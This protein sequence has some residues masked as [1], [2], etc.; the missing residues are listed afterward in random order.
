[1]DSRANN[2]SAF[3]FD[4]VQAIE[5][6]SVDSIGSLYFLLLECLVAEA[7]AE[8]RR[9]HLDLDHLASHVAKCTGLVNVLRGV[10]HNASR[11]RCYV[12]TDLLVKHGA[13][14]Q[15]FLAGD[16]SSEGVAAACYDLSCRAKEHY[17]VADSIISKLK[18]YSVKSL[19]LPI[20]FAHIFL[21]RMEEVNF[22][23]FD[24][25][26]QRRETNLPLKLWYKS[27]R[28]WLK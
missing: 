4:S 18:D 15:H 14:H 17:D 16:P 5:E 3:P 6:Y 20:T 8:V 13:A 22:N 10:G 28:L 2:V 19:F 7:G 26:L 12:P 25:K 1:M 27:W 21:R 23:V 11:G 9:K 24:S